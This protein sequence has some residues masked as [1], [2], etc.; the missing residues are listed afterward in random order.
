[1]ENN[2]E[3]NSCINF[4]FVPVLWFPF[5]Y[6]VGIGIG[7]IEVMENTQQV[8]AVPTQTAKPLRQHRPIQVTSCPTDWLLYAMAIHVRG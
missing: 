2:K 4:I 6:K 3:R 5:A 8:L 7:K 1:M